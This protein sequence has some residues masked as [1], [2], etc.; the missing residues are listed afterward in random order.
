[1]KLA[2]V[3][4]TVLDSR[5]AAEIQNIS[6]FQEDGKFSYQRYQDL[7]QRQG[8]TPA[9]FEARIVGEIMEQQLL[10][11]VTKSIVVPEIYCQE[12]TVF[13]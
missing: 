11:G 5:L 9:M 2:N 1:V 13:E 7:L 12:Y 3:G 4:L 10:E 6:F 8:M